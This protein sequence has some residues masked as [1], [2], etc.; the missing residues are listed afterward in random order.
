M[1]ATHDLKF[2]AEDLPKQVD[3]FDQPGTE[4]ER[5]MPPNISGINALQLSKFEQFHREFLCRLIVAYRG[6]RAQNRPSS[7]GQRWG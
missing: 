6:L 2:K 4:V 3:V 7:H 5:F 1:L